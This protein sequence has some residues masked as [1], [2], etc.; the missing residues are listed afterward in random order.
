MSD[1]RPVPPHSQGSWDFQH[2]Q[3]SQDF[4][5]SQDFPNSQGSQGSQGS[6]VSAGAVL[7]QAGATPLRP[8]DPGRIGPYVPL[9]LLGSGGMGRVYLART[10]DGGPGLA[11]VKVIRPEYAED[12]QFRRRFEREAAVHARVHTPARAA[13]AR[14]RIR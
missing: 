11:A 6:Q 8:A 5:H 13:A 2:S 9:G 3:G 4:P 10:V 1:Q 14:H 7:R 12:P